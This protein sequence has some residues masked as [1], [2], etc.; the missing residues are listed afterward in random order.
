LDDASALKSDRKEDRD[1]V[2]SKYSTELNVMNGEIQKPEKIP[3]INV[4]VD[5]VSAS[6][7][8]IVSRLGFSSA[9]LV[10]QRKIIK[11]NL[12]P[13]NFNFNIEF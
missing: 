6:F 2:L 11:K 9:T 4:S 3:H 13:V 12:L 1:A 8:D 5:E 10:K 7:Q